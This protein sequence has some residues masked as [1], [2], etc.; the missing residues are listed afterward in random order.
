MPY[1]RN[2]D[3]FIDEL[4]TLA[5]T[6]DKYNIRVVYA[7]HQFHTSSWL[8]PKNGVGFPS[9][10]FKNDSNNNHSLS[11]YS[12]GSC[13]SPKSKVAQIWWSNY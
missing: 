5:K 13:G 10:L 12:Y 9:L 3:Q 1:I 8:D 4:N 7:N 6:A 2:P 11:L